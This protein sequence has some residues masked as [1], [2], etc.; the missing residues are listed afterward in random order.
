MTDFV[1]LG[2]AID[3]DVLVYAEGQGDHA[4]C[5]TARDVLGRLPV[6]NIM[7]PAQVLGELHRV[8]TRR[9]WRDAVQAR[10]TVLQWADTF[11]VCDSSWTA[12][13]AAMDL[14]A[15]HQLQ[16]WDGLILAVAAEDR[17]RILLSEDF[18]H[19]FTWRGV[20]VVSPFAPERHALLEQALRN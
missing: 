15:D 16:I 6:G 20:T 19:G 10:Q 11:R 18:Q 5:E 1:A 2:V 7:L 3:T 14:H 4:R 13:Q 9:A 17:C 12:L 8:L